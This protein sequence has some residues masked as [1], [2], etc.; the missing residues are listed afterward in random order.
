MRALDFPPT[1]TEVTAGRRF[2]EVRAAFPIG[3]ITVV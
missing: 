3:P 2:L 1:V